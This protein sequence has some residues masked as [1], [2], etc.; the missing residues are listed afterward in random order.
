MSPNPASVPGNGRAVQ[1]ES[2]S[3]D[4]VEAS[5]AFNAAFDELDQVP[6]SSEER[7]DLLSYYEDVFLPELQTRTGGTYDAKS[8][9]PNSAAGQRLQTLYSTQGTPEKSGQIADPGDG[10]DW[11][12]LNAR[13]QPHYQAMMEKMGYDDIFLVN[14]DGQVVY[15]ANKGIDLGLNLYDAPTDQTELSMAVREALAT[16]SVDAMVATSVEAWIPSL[17]EPAGWLVSPVGRAGDLSGVLVAHASIQATSDTMT[18]DENWVEQGLGETGE[19]YLSQG[20]LMISNSRTLIENPE[21]YA[22]KAAANGTPQSVVDQAVQAGSSVLLQ[23][24]E[25]EAIDLA[26]RGETGITTGRNYLG[27]DVLIAYGPMD[28]EGSQIGVIATME[29]SEAFAPVNAFARA[30]LISTALMILFFAIFSIALARVFTRPIDRLLDAVRRTGAGERD[31]KVDT[32][33]K[34]EFAELGVAFNDMS[35]SMQAKADLLEAER[36]E[37]ER[38]LLS[39]MPATVADRYRQG[40]ETIASDHGDVTV[41]YA[42][43][44][45]F[46]DYADGMQSEEALAQLNEILAGL[47]EIASRLGVDRVRTTKR[48]YLASCGLNVPR[49]DSA[50]RVVEFA[51]EADSFVRRLARQYETS[52]SLRAG[53]DSGSVTS[54][55]VGRKSVVYDMW[56]DAVDLAYRLQGADSSPGMFISDRVLDRIGEMFEVEEAEPGNALPGDRKVWRLVTESQDD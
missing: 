16:N 56:G 26:E 11:S 51:I 41:I 24:V 7:Q 19:V 54:G 46:D 1:F 27:E 20:G 8:L 34:D 40:D 37:S 2:A 33:S 21:D 18:G 36:A 53:I 31:V 5:K 9:M 44:V 30:V 39:L 14:M 13:Y 38:V 47:D 43:L 25:G 32:G 4:T 42:D 28:I 45:G 48:G 50:R 55:I 52:L 12:A 15:T 17:N 22:K 23:P 3:T 6:I 49:V 10:S 35:N 29:E